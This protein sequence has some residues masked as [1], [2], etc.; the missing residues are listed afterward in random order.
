MILQH[1]LIALLPNVLA[2]LQQGEPFG[3]QR[4]AIRE[5]WG[6]RPPDAIPPACDEPVHVLRQ[7]LDQVEPIGH[8][9]GVW[10]SVGDGRSKLLGP[11]AGDH[12]N[13]RMLFEPGGDRRDRSVRKQ[14]NHARPLEIDHDG[15]IPCAPFPGKVVETDNSWCRVGRKR[16]LMDEPQQRSSSD[17]DPLLTREARTS[18][19]S[20]CYAHRPQP[21]LQGSR[22]PCMRLDQVR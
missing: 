4:K 3:R 17:G 8:V 19:A 6:Q 18:F 10:E 12:V 16:H 11:V 9:L 21:A 13:G 15:A 20:D 7:I 5:M 2:R 1:A 14:G 22:V